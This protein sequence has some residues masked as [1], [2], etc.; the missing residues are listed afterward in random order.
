MEQPAAVIMGRSYHG[1]SP[2]DVLHHHP[3]VMAG[4]LSVQ[5]HDPWSTG[6]NYPQPTYTYGAESWHSGYSPHRYELVTLPG[7][8]KKCYGCGAEFTDRQRSPPHNIVVKHVDR[9]LVR[10]DE[11]TGNFLFSA[12]YSNTYY[13][14]DFSHIQ[15]K[16]PFFTGQVFIAFD[17]LSSLNNSQCNI[18]ENCNLK[19]TVN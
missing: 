14:L 18:I 4:G 10:R 5:Q 12:D 19:V 17:K 7:N 11:R 15:R 8:V 6:Q 3:P 13:H 2:Q 1:V 9:R 16:N